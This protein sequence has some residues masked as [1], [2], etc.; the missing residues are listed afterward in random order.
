MHMEMGSSLTS[1]HSVVLNQV[2]PI[3][4]ICLDECIGCPADSMNHSDC[5]FIG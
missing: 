4:V 1:N 3:W 2:E 5:L